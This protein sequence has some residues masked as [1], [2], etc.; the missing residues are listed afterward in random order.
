MTSGAKTPIVPPK[1][2][3]RRIRPT[4]RPRVVLIL[5]RINNDIAITE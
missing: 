4:V 3:P 5:T 1:H 2:K